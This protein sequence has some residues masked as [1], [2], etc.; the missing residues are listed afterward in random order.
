VEEAVIV[1]AIR[2]PIGTAFKG[3]LTETSAE[4]LAT[5]VL[6][7]AVKASNV[8]P[9]SIDDVIFGETGNG[10]SCLARYAAVANG[11]ESVAGQAV[12]RWCASGLVAI[13]GAAAT[14]RAGVDEVIVAGGVHS[15]S[16]G[17]KTRWRVLG[18]TDEFTE[19]S[20]GSFPFDADAT[21]D[22][23]LSVG[24]NVAQLAG[25]SREDMDRWAW[26]SHMRAAEAIAQGKFLDEI[27]PITVQTLDGRTIEF[28]VDEHPRAGSTL[29]KLATL[30]PLHPEIPDFSITAGNAA[31]V[32]D[33]ASALVI[34]SRS[35]A[36]AHG[37]TPLA[38]VR[39]WAAEG[40]APRLTGMG[41]IAAAQKVLQRNG[42][43]VDEIDLWEIN[44]AFASVSVAACKMMNIDEEKVNIYGSGCSLG[45]PIAA[46]GARMVTTMVHELRRRGGGRGLASMCAAGG[47]GG[48]LIIE[49]D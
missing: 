22:V 40:V 9:E 28:S 5:F 45:H 1:S 7:E 27:R 25:L 24:W 4:T 38:R 29:E 13:S 8:D 23:T 14:I 2:T 15:S 42:L 33:A 12:Q 30:K 32:N 46:S 49:V 3:S 16:T 18:T 48:A 37:L 35:Y 10:G 44:E 47:Q 34:T 41:A 36:E 6:R 43:G 26:R 11:M 20:K 39:S 19:G 21:D 31:G 17:P